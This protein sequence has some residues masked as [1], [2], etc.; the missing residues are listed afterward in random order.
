MY[1]DYDIALTN[2]LITKIKA[3][4]GKITDRKI[5]IALLSAHVMN[6]S[7]ANS[8]G[9]LGKKSKQKGQKKSRLQKKR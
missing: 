2:A 6:L 7:L 5:N 3:F 1:S 9:D 8:K 4:V